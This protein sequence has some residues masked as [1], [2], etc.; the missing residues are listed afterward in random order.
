MVGLVASYIY[1]TFLTPLPFKRFKFPG[2]VIQRSFIS[3]VFVWGG[4]KSQISGTFQVDSLDL[5]PPTQD[6]G[7]SVRCGDPQI[8]MIN[9]S[10]R[11]SSW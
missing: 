2:S 1:Y 9:V 11:L 6:D 7:E 4:G 5:Q 8:C 10:C 3:G